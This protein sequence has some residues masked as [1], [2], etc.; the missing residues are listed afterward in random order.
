MFSRMCANKLAGSADT[1]FLAAGVLPT[2]ASNPPP[3]PHV[4]NAAWPIKRA[5]Y[6]NVSTAVYPRHTLTIPPRPYNW[7]LA[8]SSSRSMSRVDP[9]PDSFDGN[10]NDLDAANESTR[11]LPGDDEEAVSSRT[12]RRRGLTPLPK[13]QLG[14]LIAVRIVDPIAYQQI[15]PYINQLLADMGVAKPEQ[16]GFYSGLVVRMKC[17]GAGLLLWMTGP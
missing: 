6:D 2:V 10:H 9:S 16:V 7:M 12:A 15:F 8:G 11:L 17:L 13:T 5:R 3:K 1:L 14:A 4:S